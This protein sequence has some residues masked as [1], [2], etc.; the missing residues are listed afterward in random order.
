MCSSLEAGKPNISSHITG[1]LENLSMSA[2]ERMLDFFFGEIF[3]TAWE[4][5]T[6]VLS[7]S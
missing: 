7:K 2:V 4:E 5:H 3:G 6:G 1:A